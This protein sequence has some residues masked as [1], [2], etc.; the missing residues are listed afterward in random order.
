MLIGFIGQGFIGKNYA[1]DFEER[2]YNVLRYDIDSYSSNKEFI[3]ICD[4]VF[5]A[6][7]TPTIKEKFSDKIL[8]DVMSLVGK[9][10][11]AIIKS[12]V[13]LGTT[14]KIQKMFPNVYVMHS[15][16]F[17]TEVTA[18][19]DARSPD[20][21]II[22]YTRKSK[23]KCQEVIDIMA[24]AKNDYFMPCTEAE[25]VK[26]AGNFWFYM[27]VV[28]INTIADLCKA[29]GLSYGLVKEGMMGDPRI[30]NTHLDVL[31]KS[32]RG[33]GGHCFIKDTSCY[34]QM[35]KEV[36][37]KNSK[38]IVDFISGAEEYNNNLLL[39]SD[40]DLDIL[41]EVYNIKNMKRD[42]KDVSKLTK[43]KVISKKPTA[44]KPIPKKVAPKK[45]VAV[46][47][48]VATKKSSK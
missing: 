27:K 44:I 38:M 31:H 1:D 33:A 17:L 48:V 42:V 40:K 21:N 2:S 15:P 24:P 39:E 35:H 25:M 16:E 46:K 3:S 36:K 11:V 23:K 20:R 7:P 10:K 18:K 29:H 22:G 4:Y 9:G 8:I 41:S 12:T 47:K 30:G 43:K 45:K 37:G 13:K 26:Y 5:I 14:E 6:V 19:E 34:K 28:T 32:G